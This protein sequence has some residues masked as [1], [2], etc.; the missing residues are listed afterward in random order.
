MSIKILV[1]ERSGLSGPR[2]R[3][4]AESRRRSAPAVAV[5][6]V[7]AK[8]LAMMLGFR[9]FRIASAAT[10]RVRW[11]LHA[12]P[13]NVDDDDDGTRPCLLHTSVPAPRLRE[14]RDGRRTATT[15]YVAVEVIRLLELAGFFHSI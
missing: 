15:L 2:R 1:R 7:K 8:I 4:K 10:T 11:L 5:R 6:H 9:S 14:R 12:E 3:S 13:A